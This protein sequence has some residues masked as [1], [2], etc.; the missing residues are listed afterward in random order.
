MVE[1]TTPWTVL[2]DPPRDGAENMALDHALALAAGSSGAPTLRLYRW[3]HPTLSVGRHEPIAATVREVAWA[4]GVPVVRRPTGGRSVWHHR[5]ITYAVALPAALAWGARE[6]YQRINGALVEALR[7]LGVEAR[8]AEEGSRVGPLDG[9]DC[10]SRPAPGE[11]VVGG[12]KLVGSAQARLGNALLQHGSVLLAGGQRRP[13]EPDP[14][15]GVPG[16]VT[17]EEV[18]GYAPEE[19]VVMEALLGGFRAGL[20][21]CWPPRGQVAVGGEPPPRLLERYRDPAWTWRR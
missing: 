9:G 16:E 3:A 19:E 8:Q 11:V 13:W 6:T 12:R 17:L 15:P 1:T 10:F 18:L 4:G 21:G 5:E 7:H 14:S 2:V 20:G